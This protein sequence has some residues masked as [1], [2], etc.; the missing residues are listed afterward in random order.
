M[1]DLHNT[2]LI[3]TGIVAALPLIAAG[4]FLCFGWPARKAQILSR[5]TDDSIKHYR[6]TF[7]PS[8]TFSNTA[9]FRKEYDRRYGRRLF[10]FPVL[11][12]AATLIFVT[13]FSASWV[14]LH[15]WWGASEGTGKIAI[16]SLAGAYIWVTYD[17]IFRV[18]QNDVV[19]S[20]INRATLRLLLSLPFGFA[21][22]A[23]AGEVPGM[24]GTRATSALAF[25]VGS[26]PT[27]TVLKFMRRTAFL[28]L[29]LDANVEDDSLKQL[30]KIDG[31]TTP[32]A[33][34]FIDE[35][36]RTNLQLAYADPI[37]LTIKSGMDFAF[38]LSCCGHAMVRTYFNDEQMKVVDKYGLLTGLEMIT[39]NKAL[40]GYDKIRN[41]AAKA[42]VA[43]KDP[44]VEQKQAQQ[45]LENFA[46]ALL[47]DPASARFIVDQ[48]A[49][50]PYVGFTWW[51]WPE[52]ATENIEEEEAPW[53]P[54]ALPTPP[55]EKKAMKFL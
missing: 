4:H 18:R 51:M 46:T 29:K 55:G 44:D 16:S 30:M 11:L 15:D 10:F 38:I 17:L 32:V 43:P 20:D 26:F 6:E 1:S 24:T 5:F 9:E 36:I 52:T 19:T 31:I 8:G 12:F 27:D 21:I 25:F 39:L 45:L 34:R 50:D 13:Y 3:S 42:G 47:L 33:E 23:F 14:W 22:A 2:I 48:I 28:W 7:C 49:A 53:P 37:S 40:L 54:P 35:G 41:E